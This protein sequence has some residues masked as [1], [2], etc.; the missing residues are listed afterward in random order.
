MKK[1]C[2]LKI[3]KKENFSGP[4]AMGFLEF[5]FMYER[6]FSNNLSN[7]KPYLPGYM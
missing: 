5:F 7:P 4:N 3:K 2:N 6:H 1:I